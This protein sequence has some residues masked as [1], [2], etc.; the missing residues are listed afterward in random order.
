MAHLR[1]SL[2]HTAAWADARRVCVREM[3][4][5]DVGVVATL[6]TPKQQH[7]DKVTTTVLHGSDPDKRCAAS[8]IAS[9]HHIRS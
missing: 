6:S 9:H 1:A 4:W 7:G 8:T 2:L 5:V 3:G